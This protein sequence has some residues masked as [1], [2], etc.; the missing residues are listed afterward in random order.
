MYSYSDFKDT[1]IRYNFMILFAVILIIQIGI[2]LIPKIIKYIVNLV[3][4]IRL[5]NEYMKEKINNTELIREINLKY[6]PAVF[7]MIID[8]KMEPKKDLLAN[9]LNLVYKEIVN[10]ETVGEYY[11]VSIKEENVNKVKLSQ[12]EAF[13]LRYIRKVSDGFNSYF[14]FDF[15]EKEIKNELK[16]QGLIEEEGKKEK[17]LLLLQ[18]TIYY[19]SMLL[20]ILLP[21]TTTAFTALFIFSMTPGNY[22]M[23]ELHEKLIK[24]VPIVIYAITVVLNII[25]MV[26]IIKFFVVKTKVNNTLILDLLN[27]WIPIFSRAITFYD[28]LVL[29]NVWENVYENKL[30]I[31][32]ILAYA[33]VIFSLYWILVRFVEYTLNKLKTQYVL[34]IF[35]TPKGKE[36]RKKMLKFKQFLEEYTLIA[37]KNIDAIVVFDWYI[38]YSFSVNTNKTLRSALKKLI[39]EKNIEKFA[40]EKANLII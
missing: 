13:V 3:R 10:F 36:E 24:F 9:I 25:F 35:L 5:K 34:P 33:T 39:I 12:D 40:K 37:N 28:I 31:G 26:V 8:R 38:P 11:K 1:Q 20:E 15:F 16:K 23:S 21:V 17:C 29:Y 27:K 22:P 4:N 32:E 19:I 6:S 18:K 30:F 2:I 14:D 7:S